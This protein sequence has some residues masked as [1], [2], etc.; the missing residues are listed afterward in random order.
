MDQRLRHF[1][2]ITVGHVCETFE[3]FTKHAHHATRNILHHQ[4]IVHVRRIWQHDANQTLVKIV[5]KIRA[6]LPV[7]RIRI[8]EFQ[9]S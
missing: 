9:P 3:P 6:Q 4:L 2:K 8:N 5:N 7:A 1:G